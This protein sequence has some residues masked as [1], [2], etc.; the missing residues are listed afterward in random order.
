MHKSSWATLVAATLAAGGLA[1]CCFGGNPIVPPPP[2]TSTTTP[3]VTP[4]VVGG[5]AITLAPGFA[6]DPT[7]VT[8]TAGGPVQAST[9]GALCRG[10]IAT[11]PNFT[12]TTT[13]A[14]PNLRVLV[15]A[16]QD[17]T[18]VV[19]LSNGQVLCDDDG[20]GYPNP[21]VAGAFPP[22][23]HQVYVGT[24]SPTATGTPFTL[25]FTTNSMAT[26]TTLGAP[27][28]PTIP[29]TVGGAIPTQCGLAV[30]TF[31]P[32]SIGTSVVPGAHTPYVGPDGLGGNVAAGDENSLNWVPDMQ[33]YVGQ[34][35]TITSLEGMDGAG[36]PVVKIAA[37]SGAFY[38]RIRDMT[39]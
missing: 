33:P 18:L 19:R 25:G 24:Y 10:T 17:T 35:T 30:A 28:P 36:C 11:A 34:R 21:A 29:P 31:G 6:P 23:Q 1:G 26:P 12:L 20:G 32:L 15:N 4:P 13:G 2:V 3:P 16:A 5:S 7:V 9:M 27:M 37:D 22:G 38:W 14:F 8:G 39:L